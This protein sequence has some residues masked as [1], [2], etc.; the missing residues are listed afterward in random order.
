MVPTPHAHSLP[1]IHIPHQCGPSVTIHEP[2]LTCHYHPESMVSLLGFTLD[3]VH[4]T[5]FDTC[6]HHNSSM[7]SSCTVLKIPWALPIRPALL[8]NPWQPLSCLLSLSFCF[9]QKVIGLEL[10]CM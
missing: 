7:Q 5:G 1:A 4:S 8:P 9:I 2:A 10:Y 6:N 3:V